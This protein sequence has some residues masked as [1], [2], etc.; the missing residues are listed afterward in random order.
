MLGINFRFKKKEKT[1]VPYINDIL[2]YEIIREL[3]TLPIER[4][5]AVFVKKNFSGYTPLLAVEY[6]DG[7]QFGLFE[8]TYKPEEVVLANNRIDSDGII[9]VHNHP[10]H[11]NKI[12]KAYPS[13]GDIKSTIACGEEWQEKG[14]VL[15][16]HIIVNEI[17]Y[18][19][20]V[21]NGLIKP[22]LDI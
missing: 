5:Y 1:V 16:D 15:L 2:E 19:S 12:V 9:I 17:Q 22:C 11:L 18:Y 6:G 3:R 13:K 14:C 8:K 7:D 21:E 20:F 10:R 4:I